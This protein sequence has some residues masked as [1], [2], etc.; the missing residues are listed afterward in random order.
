MNLTPAQQREA[1]LFKYPKTYRKWLLRA[2][3][4]A[5]KTV[6][7][8]LADLYA[9]DRSVYDIA[10]LVGATQMGVWKTMNRLNIKR[11]LPAVERP[12]ML[13]IDGKHK[14]GDL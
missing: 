4:M 1:K 5:Y 12:E 6:T 7:E 8:M 2:E 3:K 11:R 14:I 10:N 13:Y 9:G